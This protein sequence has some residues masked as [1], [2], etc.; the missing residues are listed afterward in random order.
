MLDPSLAA[1]VKK[2][3]E[4]EKEDRG[5]SESESEGEYTKK[6]PKKGRTA[7]AAPRGTAAICHRITQLLDGV[8]VRNLI[9][10]MYYQ[11]TFITRLQNSVK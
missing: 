2:E 9:M 10:H 8:Q 3:K 7:S 4:K 6:R 1:V 5:D 11:H